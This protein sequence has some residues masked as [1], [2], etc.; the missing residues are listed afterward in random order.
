M[1]AAPSA[2]SLQRR[3]VPV[4]LNRQEIDLVL[5][6]RI[7]IPKPERNELCQ[8]PV[9][10]GTLHIEGQV[11]SVAVKF[12]VRHHVAWKE[13]ST[14]V[15]EYR[16][17]AQDDEW[18]LCHVCELIGRG[19]DPDRLGRCSRLEARRN[20]AGTSVSNQQRRCSRPSERN[21]Q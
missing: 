5:V 6:G 9:P 18:E 11:A 16:Q 3:Y 19:P 1:S 20:A 8:H 12:S 21:P 15:P 10:E 2:G 13:P 4:V 14:C 7:F 17:W